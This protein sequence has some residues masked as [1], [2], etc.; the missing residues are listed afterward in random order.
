MR[1]R[2]FGGGQ[3]RAAKGP[4]GD[5]LVGSIMQARHAAASSHHVA[6]VRHR[7]P[8]VINL[9]LDASPGLIIHHV[10]LGNKD[11]PAGLGFD[12]TVAVVYFDVG[13]DAGD[14]AAAA[15]RLNY[16]ISKGRVVLNV[17][18][19]GVAQNV[20][21]ADKVYVEVAGSKDGA[22]SNT[23]ASMVAWASTRA[24]RVRNNSKVGAPPPTV[25]TAPDEPPD[26][27]DGAVVIGV[28][29]A[30]AVLGAV[31]VAA[32]CRGRAKAAQQREAG[33]GARGPG[34]TVAN[35]TFDA[36]NAYA[37]TTDAPP[38]Y[39]DAGDA[40]GAGTVYANAGEKAPAAGDEVY[41][42]VDS[43]PA[44]L[45]QAGATYVEPTPL[46]ASEAAYAS[47]DDGAS[48]QAPVD[49]GAYE[50]P[51]GQ[52]PVDDGT[53]EMPSTPG[54]GSSGAAKVASAALNLYETVEDQ[55]GISI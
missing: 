18:I 7:A 32:V 3:W 54:G 26:G 15:V 5:Q 35:E 10:E 11:K 52:A 20:A 30:L 47:F 19:A 38:P 14:I 33:V 13:T 16:H 2:V 37:D 28:L 51:F 1:V 46:A 48:G 43:T 31:V 40:E 4:V 53:Y 25:A 8:Q 27:G 45:Q 24:T 9:T 55:P 49:D 50:M 29:C 41:A 36:F 23:A 6:G 17:V 44:A 39:D 21:L 12:A 42:D 22:A 34:V